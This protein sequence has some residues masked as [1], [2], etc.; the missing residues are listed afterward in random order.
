MFSKIINKIMGQLLSPGDPL[1]NDYPHQEA[2]FA[3]IFYVKEFHSSGKGVMD[4]WDSLPG[5]EK[6][7][8]EQ[9]VTK[10][11]KSGWR[12]RRK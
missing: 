4:F 8:C 10:V 2:V 1:Y 5:F 11:K 12:W 3:S 9:A 7:I 6:Y